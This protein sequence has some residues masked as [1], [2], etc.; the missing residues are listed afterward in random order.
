M[1]DLVLVEIGSFRSW[2]AWIGGGL[3]EAMRDMVQLAIGSCSCL[4]LTDTW[5]FL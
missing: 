3:V 2:I 1:L 5:V 4:K